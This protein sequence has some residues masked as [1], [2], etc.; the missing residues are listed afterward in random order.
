MKMNINDENVMK[1]NNEENE[2]KMKYEIIIMK[3]KW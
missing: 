3:R 2:M 1:E